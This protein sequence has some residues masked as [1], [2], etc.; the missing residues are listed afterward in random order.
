MFLEASFL[1]VKYARTHTLKTLASFI[2]VKR[3]IW[4]VRPHIFLMACLHTHRADTALALQ[5]VVTSSHTTS[6]FLVSP[7]N[8]Q[9]G[10]RLT[11]GGVCFFFFFFS[12][13]PSQCLGTSGWRWSRRQGERWRS[14]LWFDRVGLGVGFS[15]TNGMVVSL[16]W[17]VWYKKGEE[18]NDLKWVGNGTSSLTR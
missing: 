17:L 6:H 7:R 9:K 2:A 16:I 15:A 12:C 13:P 11:W 3:W 18:F 10:L 4:A 1:K 14:G 5:L 8:C